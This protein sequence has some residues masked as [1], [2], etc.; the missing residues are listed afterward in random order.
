VEQT[1]TPVPAQAC[2]HVDDEELQVVQDERDV[3]YLSV[4][5][6]RSRTG[7][8]SR[9]PEDKVCGAPVW[10][11]RFCMWTYEERRDHRMYLFMAQ[12]RDIDKIAFQ[13]SR[14]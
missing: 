2:I 7:D 4:E 1:G 14:C 8:G 6:R 11:H 3:H 13:P 10:I 12:V 5:R 9:D